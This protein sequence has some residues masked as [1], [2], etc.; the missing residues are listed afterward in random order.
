M[1]N[2]SIALR[3]TLGIIV[4]YFIVKVLCTSLCKQTAEYWII[5]SISGVEKPSCTIFYTIVTTRSYF[6][7]TWYFYEFHQR[8]K[9]EK[10][11]Q[12]LIK[13]NGGC[14]HR[15]NYCFEDEMR[16]HSDHQED[17]YQGKYQ[18]LG[19]WVFIWWSSSWEGVTIVFLRRGITLLILLL[20]FRSENWAS[21]K[22]GSSLL[23]GL[24]VCHNTN[25]S[26]ICY[27][28]WKK[29]ALTTHRTYFFTFLI[30]AVRSSQVLLW[31]CGM[32]LFFVGLLMKLFQLV[33]FIKTELPTNPSW[34]Y[35]FFTNSCRQCWSHF[36][37]FG[38]QNSF[39]PIS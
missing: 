27:C 4:C 6:T 8:R 32:Y 31:K 12:I 36:T 3:D 10:R 17:E 20:R 15:T 35:N 33:G 34:H 14:T 7:Q 5:T 29:F 11:C 19:F 9:L 38:R 30:K 26:S 23:W 25:S 24:S 16:G 2:R 13:D 39:D 21:S 37:E 22:E 18:E 28:Q 1:V